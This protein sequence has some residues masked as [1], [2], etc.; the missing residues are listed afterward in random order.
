MSAPR[1]HPLPVIRRTIF[2]VSRIERQRLMKSL[3]GRI[4]RICHRTFGRTDHASARSHAAAAKTTLSR[5]PAHC[6]CTAHDAK[7]SAVQ[8]AQRSS[9][10]WKCTF[11]HRHAGACGADGSRAESH[12]KDRTTHGNVSFWQEAGTC[13]QTCA[14]QDTPI[15]ALHQRA[16]IVPTRLQ[17]LSKPVMLHIQRAR[18]KTRLTVHKVIIPQSPE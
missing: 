1:N 3:Q 15:S 16:T 4:M 5:M 9:V 7:L 2:I 10:A 17:P 12:C 11:G 8:F 13:K 18:L 6:P 14:R